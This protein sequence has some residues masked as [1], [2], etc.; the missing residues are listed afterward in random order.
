[1]AR[2]V[3]R[4]VTRVSMTLILVTIVVM[5]AVAVIQQ[6]TQRESRDQWRNNIVIVIG[7]IVVGAN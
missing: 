4:S 7:V 3:T 1:M 2:T 5:R 6:R